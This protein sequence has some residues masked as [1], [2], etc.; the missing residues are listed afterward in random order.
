MSRRW[1]SKRE[2]LSKN[3]RRISSTFHLVYTR[4]CIG[5]VL[6]VGMYI[7]KKNRTTPG[8]PVAIVL[9]TVDQKDLTGN[10]LLKMWNVQLVFLPNLIDIDGVA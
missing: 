3:I 4:I 6:A 5:S 8:V 10:P 2:E 1:Y 9:F 7:G